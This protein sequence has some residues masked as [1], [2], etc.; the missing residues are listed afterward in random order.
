MLKGFPSKRQDILE[1]EE[2]RQRLESD[3]AQL[4]NE[5]NSL[6]TQISHLVAKLDYTNRSVQEKISKLEQR[7]KM[8]EASIVLAK[9]EASDIIDKA[10]RNADIIIQEVVSSAQDAL[11]EISTS[12]NYT[13]DMSRRL[14]FKAEALEHI[15]SGI[16][17]E[18]IKNLIIFNEEHDTF[19]KK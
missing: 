17:Q 4:I 19:F 8:I 13:Y 12:T 18:E 7:E 6:K 14:E 1:L 3:I 16:D 5:N 11:K 9:K 15:L 10:Y 2:N